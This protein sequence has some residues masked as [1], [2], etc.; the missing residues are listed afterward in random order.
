MFDIESLRISCVAIVKP[1]RRLNC[2]DLSIEMSKTYKKLSVVEKTADFRR[3][4]RVVEVTL[5][6]PNDDQVLI[7]NIY[8][9]VNATDINLTAARYFTDGKLPFDVGLEVSVMDWQK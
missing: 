6:P 4:V 7:K 2:S 5:E 8:A 9:G 1:V 3:A